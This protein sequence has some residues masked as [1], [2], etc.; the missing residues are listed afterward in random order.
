MDVLDKFLKQYSYKF[1]KGYPNMD[2]P[3][4][5]SL[6]EQLLKQLISEDEID[7]IKVDI[8]TK[9][10]IKVDSPTKGGSKNYD[11]TIKYALAKDNL[12]RY[13]E[14]LKEQQSFRLQWARL[15]YMYGPGQNPKSLIPQLEN[16]IANKLPSFDTSGGEQLRDYLPVQEVV[17]QIVN[18]FENPSVGTFNVC[19]G[20]PISVRRLIERRILE[21]NSDMSLNFGHYPY[22]DYEPMAFWGEKDDL[23]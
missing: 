9:E 15:F 11:D 23:I 18:I 20:K 3:K 22:P 6:L 8:S 19:S 7:D 17:R 13:L 5:K 14:L 12:R 2:N 21:L 10:K 4:D 16:A 1:D